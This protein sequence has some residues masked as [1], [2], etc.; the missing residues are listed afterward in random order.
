M[1]GLSQLAG[2]FMLVKPLVIDL[3]WGAL[4]SA[5]VKIPD[6]GFQKPQEATAHRK[7]LVDQYVAAFRHVEAAAA[8]EAR[9]ALM[10]LSASISTAVVGE[11]HSALRALVDGQLAKLA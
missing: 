3:G 2:E 10:S 5:L 1:A 7:A 9:S 4:K 11:Q 8:G 6:A